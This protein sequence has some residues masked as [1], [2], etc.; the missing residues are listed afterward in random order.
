[1]IGCSKNK[2]YS[3]KEAIQK[4]DVVFLNKIFNFERFE[5][6]LINV[7]KNKKDNIRVTGY[8]DEGDPIFKDLIFDGKEIQY[9]Y[10]DSKDAFGG[11]KWR[12][13]TDVC[14]KI[15]K[16]KNEQGDIE[17]IVRG[18]KK[19]NPDISYFLIRV[20]KSKS[21]EINQN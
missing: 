8:T 7:S 4:G 19:N 1:M 18:C 11:S 9:S 21:V 2:P 12:I 14:K 15:I 10:D 17:Y 3:S 20:A 6:F 16:E 13:K 5:Q